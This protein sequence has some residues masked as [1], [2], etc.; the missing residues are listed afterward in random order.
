MKKILF[1]ITIILT[2]CHTANAQSRD[3]FFRNLNNNSYNNRIV[4]DAN[5]PGIVMPGDDIFGTNS[6]A[7]G[8]PTGSGLL[9]LTS[10]GAVYALVRKFRTTRLLKHMAHD[11]Y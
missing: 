3:D 11:S 4:D 10:L 5:T 7:T 2:I 1:A 9:V 8:A 6:N